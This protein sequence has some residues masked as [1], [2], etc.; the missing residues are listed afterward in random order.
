MPNLAYHRRLAMVLA[1]A[2]AAGG[3]AAALAPAHPAGAAST[4][5]VSYRVDQWTGGFVG[6]VDVTAGAAPVHG[7][8]VTWTYTAG[9]QITSFFSAQVSQSG[10]A[11]TA[12]NLSWNG[13]LAPN[14][15]TEFG[16][17]GTWTGS[18]PAPTDFAV[19]GSGCDATGP[20][21]GPSPSAAA[22]PSQGASP[23]VG[24]SPSVSPS[25][26]S[27]SGPPP[28][29]C[30][31]A[32]ICDG[33]ENQPGGTPSGD[34]G[35]NFPNCS[36]AGTAT[37]D[38]TVAH[39]GGKS[40]KV[41]GAAGYCNHI[42]VASTK[43]LS[44]LGSVWYA[45]FYIRH[46]TALPTA[47]VTFAAMRDAADGNND[48]RMGGQNGALQWNRQSDDATLPAQSPAGVA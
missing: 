43:D 17:Q 34:W 8:T 25:A 21:P 16:V 12:T 45:R 11:V 23:S 4:C 38:G 41:T 31:T 48:L 33:F 30:G 32:V 29:G 2:L 14:A 13:D 39:A 28:G 24:S 47:H 22:S 37:I 1:A 19:T 36:G 7:W 9:Q 35:L 27:S 10:A 40:L 15:T 26:G 42:F 5:Q 6:Y 3:V 46:T 18:N 44:G 20:T